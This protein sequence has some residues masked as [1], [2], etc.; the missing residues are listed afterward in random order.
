MVAWAAALGAVLSIMCALALPE[1]ALDKYFGQ[2]V[3]RGVF[4]NKN[5]LGNTM[6]L[7][8]LTWL[9]VV[10][11]ADRFRWLGVMMFTTCSLLVLL[12]RSETSLVVEGL[13]LF[14]MLACANVHRSVFILAVLCLM[15]LIT[16]CIVEIQHPIDVVLGLL[17]RDEDLTGRVKIWALVRE[18][19]SRHPWLGYGYMAFWRGADGPSFDVNVGGW[20]PPHAHNGFLDLA[21]EFGVIGP[22]L[23]AVVLT[24]RIIYSLKVA[25]RRK[26]SVEL[27]PLIVLLFIASSN[28]TEGANMTPGTI[29]WELFVALCVWSS[30]MQPRFR[31]HRLEIKSSLWNAVGRIRCQVCR[32]RFK[33]V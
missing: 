1:Y 22:I 10:L 6:V 30:I 20:I 26:S 5:A 2:T 32:M 18:A 25:Q 31:R 33:R 28:V 8:A 24:R 15:L 9:I 3:W 4:D 7:G 19:I 12:S 23:F 14:V 27:F 21:L 11:Q 17:N 16:V 13:L 29:G